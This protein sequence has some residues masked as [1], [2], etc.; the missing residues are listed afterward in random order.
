MEKPGFLGTGAGFGGV[1]LE[2]ENEDAEEMGHVAGE[3]EDVHGDGVRF[4]KP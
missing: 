3:S 4:R 2:E 1:D